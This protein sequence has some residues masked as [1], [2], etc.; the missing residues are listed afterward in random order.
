MEESMEYDLLVCLSE[1]KEFDLKDKHYEACSHG[2][3]QSKIWTI[4]I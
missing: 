2:T 3:E 1:Y 4:N